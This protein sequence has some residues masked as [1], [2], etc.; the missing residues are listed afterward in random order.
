M[1]VN[2][3]MLE[4]FA[5]ADLDGRVRLAAAVFIVFAMSGYT[6]SLIQPL[7]PTTDSIPTVVGGLLGAVIFTFVHR[8]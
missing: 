2:L 4:R 7:W 8:K 1:T 5:K 6:F 3:Q